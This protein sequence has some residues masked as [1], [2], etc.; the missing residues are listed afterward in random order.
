MF[1]CFI[2]CSTARRL[3]TTGVMDYTA[4]QSLN[5]LPKYKYRVHAHD[6]RSSLAHKNHFPQE[7]NMRY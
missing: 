7:K 3:K 1:V 2:K 6:S 4:E 5:E